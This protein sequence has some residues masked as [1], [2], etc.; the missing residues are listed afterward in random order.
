[1]KNEASK[2]KTTF[3][4]V[5]CCKILVVFYMFS[6][7]QIFQKSAPK[8]SSALAQLVEPLAWAS[9][10]CSFESHRWR[11]HCV[12][13]SSDTIS[14]VYIGKKMDAFDSHE[15]SNLI[16]KFLKQQ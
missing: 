6:R 2:S 4:N 7:F 5:V 1:M 15:I 12:V 13:S 11:S 16:I 3:E 14:R 10:G 8:L 9:K